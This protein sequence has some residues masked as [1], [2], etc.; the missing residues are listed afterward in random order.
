MAVTAKTGVEGRNRAVDGKLEVRYC[1][2]SVLG[3]ANLAL[4]RCAC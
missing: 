1:P 3:G 2:H 4:P